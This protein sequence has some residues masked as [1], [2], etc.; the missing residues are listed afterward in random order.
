MSS[1]QLVM[2]TMSIK[3]SPLGH[4]GLRVPATHLVSSTKVR[5]KVIK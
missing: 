2:P 5:I 1:N 3:R 4:T